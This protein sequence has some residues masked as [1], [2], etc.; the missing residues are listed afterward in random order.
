MRLNIF[1][2]LRAER[3]ARIAKEKERLT[4]QRE[5][6]EGERDVRVIIFK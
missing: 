6:R 4:R 2:L 5:R 3:E 1:F